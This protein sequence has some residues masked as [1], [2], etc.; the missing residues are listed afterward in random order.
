MTAGVELNF[1]VVRKEAK[2]AM[3]SDELRKRLE[4]LNGRPLKHVPP[5]R[6]ETVPEPD[7][8]TALRKR[9]ARQKAKPGDAGTAN[10]S[11]LHAGGPSTSRKPSVRLSEPLR[12]LPPVSLEE[13][14]PGRARAV[15]DDLVYYHLERP[16]REHASWSETLGP[17][18][19]A[20]LES[21]AF[22]SHLRRTNSILPEQILFLDLETLG[23]HNTPLFLIGLLAL[24][25]DGTV[26]CRQ[27]LARD[28]SEEAGALAAFAE[29]VRETR[30]LVTYNGAAFD[31]PMLERR[32]SVHG[33][34]LPAL[35]THLDLLP[36][37]R[38]RYRRRFPD[39]RLQ[40]LEH[41]LCG[42][43]REG[44]VPGAEI[45]AVYRHFVETGNAAALAVVLQHNLLD[46]AT[47]AELLTK[48][49]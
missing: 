31:V 8:E 3:S 25:T 17:S 36:E 9:L 11:V 30:L 38:H 49:W 4:A 33:I 20:T 16:L 24:S 37:A 39:C 19:R 2:R 10:L 5:E 1:D 23:F 21:G 15:I 42:R 45:P 34:A 43:R 46:L 44:D 47:T 29:E 13:C 40:T 12:A 28:L 35:P 32:A 27:L 48:F 41:R 18:L 6:V 7:R 22:S 26:H 14:L